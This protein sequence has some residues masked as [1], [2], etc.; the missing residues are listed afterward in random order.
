MPS[1]ALAG[2][3]WK[4]V[5]AR[6]SE[7]GRKKNYDFK[8]FLASHLRLWLGL[9]FRYARLALKQHFAYLSYF[10][11]PTML[12]YWQMIIYVVSFELTLR[13]RMLYFNSF[14]FFKNVLI[15]QSNFFKTSINLHNVRTYKVANLYK[16]ILYH[17]II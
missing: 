4:W 16:K 6:G 12:L 2:L 10:V 13:K 17:H 14:F 7:E 8:T 9:D 1:E 15:F 3:G 11:K 5:K